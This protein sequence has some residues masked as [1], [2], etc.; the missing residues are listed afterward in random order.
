MYFS[1]R[2]KTEIIHPIKAGRRAMHL[3]GPS[4]SLLG[5]I[6]M[7]YCRR[8]RHNNTT[9]IRDNTEPF[10]SVLRKQQLYCHSNK[11]RDD[12]IERVPQSHPLIH[13]KRLN[14]CRIPLLLFKTYFI[15]FS[16]LFGSFS[17][18]FF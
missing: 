1:R 17:V 2:K 5:S 7:E 6:S 15:R 13:D 3:P 14:D 10:S 12:L 16:F 8:K 4:R 9:V 18:H 11:N